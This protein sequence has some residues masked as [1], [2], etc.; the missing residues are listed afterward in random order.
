MQIIA[1]LN[2]WVSWNQ[3]IALPTVTL[4]LPMYTV[5]TANKRVNFII[6]LSIKVA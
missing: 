3:Q 2:V 4:H 1:T 6:I 5:H